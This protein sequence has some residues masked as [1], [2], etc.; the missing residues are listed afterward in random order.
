MHTC[1]LL[2]S[3]Y[4]YVHAL[5]NWA[6][7]SSHEGGLNTSA[8]FVGN[9]VVPWHQFLVAFVYA[10]GIQQMQVQKGM[11]KYIDE[12]QLVKISLLFPEIS[13]LT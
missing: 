13:V 5:I 1:A 3:K 4:V 12:Y 10:T 8:S 2:L 9:K 7:L 6:V 11:M